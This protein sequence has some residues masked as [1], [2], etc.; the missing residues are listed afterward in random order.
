MKTE[1]K[2]GMKVDDGIGVGVIS[3]FSNDGYPKVNFSPFVGIGVPIEHE[4]GARDIIYLK[5]YKEGQNETN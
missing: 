5:E 1:F 3:G 4:F 2:V